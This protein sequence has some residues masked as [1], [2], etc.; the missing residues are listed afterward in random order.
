MV[1]KA[2]PLMLVLGALACGTEATGPNPPPAPP[3]GPVPGSMSLRLGQV[4]A[5]AGGIIVLITGTGTIS[6][7]SGSAGIQVRTL[8]TS[9]GSLRVLLRGALGP[10]LLGMLQV[11]DINATYSATALEVAGGA[12]VGYVQQSPSAVQLQVV[13]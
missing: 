9:T 12:S 8:Q 7:A 5:G 11:A 1:S 6:W 2:V 10:G 13:R 3:P 4:P